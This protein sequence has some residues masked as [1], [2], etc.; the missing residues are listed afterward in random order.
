MGLRADLGIWLGCHHPL[1]PYLTA[2]KAELAL[3]HANDF[4]D[5]MP[6]PVQRTHLL[7]G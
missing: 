5:L 1:I 4:F 6:F 3:S 7:G 2:F